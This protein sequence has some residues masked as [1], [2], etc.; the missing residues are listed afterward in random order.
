MDRSRQHIET[1]IDSLTEDGLETHLQALEAKLGSRGSYV[2]DVDNLLPQALKALDLS[3]PQLSSFSW[4]ELEEHVQ[5]QQ[6]EATRLHL[7]TKTC[8]AGLEVRGRKVAQDV[9]SYGRT[10]LACKQALHNAASVGPDFDLDMEMEADEDPAKWTKSFKIINY[11]LDICREHKFYKRR[12]GGG[13][14]YLRAYVTP[15]GV[16]TCY[17]E[18]LGTVAE[19]VQRF[20][21]EQTNFKM[22]KISTDE[23]R[24]FDHVVRVLSERL[25][26]RFP[27]LEPDRHVFSFRNGVL[28][29]DEEG[30]QHRPLFLTYTS[31]DHRLSE[32]VAAKHFDA[33]MPDFTDVEDFRSIATPAVDRV[34]SDQCLP[35]EVAYWLLAMLGR[36]LFDVRER[37]AW[38]VVPWLVGKSNTGKSTILNFVVKNFYQIGDVGILE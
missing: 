15:E 18:A 33:D 30:E 31:R 36:A 5:L 34:V 21:Q 7:R 22:F 1:F 28:K 6:T 20:T 4:S 14:V 38:R 25:T 3:P 10:V 19:L 2:L 8:R 17:H 11:I 32:F 9:R 37:D 26:S 35:D 13:V 29:V 16:E 27:F 23:P 12:Q 24:T